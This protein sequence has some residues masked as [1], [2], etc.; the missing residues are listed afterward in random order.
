[1]I[2]ILVSVPFL[3]SLFE[4]FKVSLLS[5]SL[6]V[7]LVPGKWRG[8]EVR[9]GDIFNNLCLV[10]FLGREGGRGGEQNPS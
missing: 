3:F 2:L 6:H 4:F 9:W 8:G 5:L 10:Q 7:C 1:V